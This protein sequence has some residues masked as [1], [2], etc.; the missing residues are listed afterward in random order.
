[1]VESY[2][3]KEAV[4]LSIIT[5]YINR[6]VL[7]SALA[8]SMVLLLIISSSRFAYYLSKAVT[9]ELD[10]QA[11]VEI[12]I[13]LLP[14]YLST[15][16]PLGG[17]LAVLLTLGRL[18]VDHELTV[19]FANGVSQVQLVKVVLVP[20]SV[21]ALLVAFLSLWLA[22]ETSRNVEQVLYQQSHEAEFDSVVAGRFQGN[23]ERQVI[24]AEGMSDDR[25]Q[26]QNVFVFN[27][28]S[29]GAAPVVIKSTSARQV[30]NEQFQSRY[31]LLKNGSR[32]EGEP[33][34][35]DYTITHFEE[36]AVR[37]YTQEL[38][39][40]ITR[41]FTL[42]TNVLIGS[43]VA[44][45]RAQLY[46]RISLPLMTLIVS[47]VAIALGQVSPRKGRFTR[48]L[49]AILVYLMYLSALTSFRDDMSK[50]LAGADI[51]IVALH[52]GFLVIGLL[53]L[54]A[55]P[56]IGSIVGRLRHQGNH[57]APN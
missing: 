45:H 27:R 35:L 2:V 32:T 44:D 6:E 13:N 37:L 47:F 28:P 14:A 43:P 26:L 7:V 11:V 3:P 9:G 55:G 5:R 33:G 57:H 52:A 19:L 48:L 8:V 39:I 40:N 46:W 22:P 16:L 49:P 4:T 15:L 31:L 41:G 29:S 51:K 25:Q 30:F 53:L 10:A 1:M 54:F 36:L 18:S 34:Q 42:P 12:I 56:F 38:E 21:L 17:F 24:Y 20:L 50:G 23:I